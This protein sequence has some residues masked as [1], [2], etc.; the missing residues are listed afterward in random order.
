VV[1]TG[2]VAVVHETGSRPR[3]SRRF[4]RER[5]PPFFVIFSIHFATPN[6]V[7]DFLA[8]AGGAEL[9][10]PSF[11]MTRLL[12]LAVLLPIA[13]ATLLVT[14]TKAAPPAL[15]EGVD[16]SVPADC[17]NVKFRGSLEN[18]RI[19]FEKT[20]KGHVAFIGGSITEMD[21]YRPM[22][23]ED[24]KKRFPKT[25]FTFTA[26]GIASTCSTTGAF[27]LKEQ[28][29]DQG[30]V[31]LFFVEFAVNDD[32]DAHH[33]RQE[34]IRGL[35]GIVRHTRQHNPAADI[36]VTYFVNEGMLATFKEGKEPLSS[37]SHDEVLRH[38]DIPGI[39][40]NREIF[41]RIEAGKL[42]W[43]Q[44]GG[45][46]PAPTGNRI[47]ANMID[48][49]L[50]QAWAKPLATSAVTK[51]HAMPVPLDP[52]NYE[53]AHFVDPAQA[54]IVKGWT[55]ETP[56]WSKLPGG[57]RARFDKEKMLCATEPGAEVK[58][59]FDGKG[60]G[61]FLLAGPDAGMLEASVD[62]APAK[63][64]DLFHGY[65]SGLHYPRSIMFDADLAPGAHVLTLKVSD[66]K[67]ATSKGTAARILKFCV[68]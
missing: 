55:I 15:A 13:L 34:C 17:K 65:S 56:E 58:L 35:E 31:D 26:A 30:P 43:K 66:Q 57:H 50:D 21:G 25:E 33:T 44:F 63:R 47:C 39:E 53:N 42:T 7:L 1:R 45:V 23:C 32:Q 36:V 37:S 22:V 4:H 52:N 2:T 28:V 16:V 51:P 54:E 12:T 38:Y 40:L 8:F 49:L 24:L 46:H 68:N 62:G 41:E 59:K 10:S 14:E 64:F 19:V 67:N 20:G 11:P 5:R 27:R 48:R 6:H 61:I 60:I 29:L 9:S 18:S 3:G